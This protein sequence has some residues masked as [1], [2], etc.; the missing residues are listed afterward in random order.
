LPV[1]WLLGICW[2]LYSVLWAFIGKEII[3]LNCGT[4]SHWQQ[5]LVFR[6]CR[7]YPIASVS[8]LSVTAFTYADLTVHVCPLCS[9]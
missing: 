7:E 2:A 3:E 9:L 5:T 8:N 1:V 6:R 4:L